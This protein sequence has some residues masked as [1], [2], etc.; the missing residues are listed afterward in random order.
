[1]ELDVINAKPNQTTYLSRAFGPGG[2]E[3]PS[4]DISVIY[5]DGDWEL[6]PQFW[7]QNYVTWSLGE[8]IMIS[9]CPQGS[10]HARASANMFVLLGN[11]QIKRKH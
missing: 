8:H 7:P 1:M 5:S 4:C 2:P 11:L 10:T 9:P 3:G 6:K